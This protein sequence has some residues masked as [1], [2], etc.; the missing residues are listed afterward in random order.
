[1]TTELEQ[2]PGDDLD[3]LLDHLLTHA[4]ERLEEEGDFHPFA[5]AIDEEGELRMVG[6]EPA[7]D[8]PSPQEIVDQ[9]VESLAAAAQ[10]GEIRAAA[11]CANVTLPGEDGEAEAA[12]VQL[13]HRDDDPV[14][15]ALPYEL[16][17]DH[18]HTGELIAGVGK[19][20]VFVAR[21]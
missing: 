21:T 20:R 8:E 5:A 12:V 18:I 13:E 7:T 9:L 3:A 19:H 11:V 16:H 2:T 17:G 4:V 6:M 15:I 1:M 14:D 10:R